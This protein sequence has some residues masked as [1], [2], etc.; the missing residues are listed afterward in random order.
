MLARTLSKVAARW[1]ASHDRMRVLFPELQEQCF[2]LL[3][4]SEKCKLSLVC[5]SWR[6]T[7]ACLGALWNT[8]DLTLRSPEFDFDGLLKRSGRLPLDLTLTVPAKQS[9]LRVD[10]C[11]KSQA[12]RLRS[13]T[14]TV[15]PEGKKSDPILRYPAPRLERLSLKYDGWNPAWELDNPTRLFD[16]CAP[17]LHSLY[18]EA[19]AFPVVCPA[20]AN[21]TSATVKC[22]PSG[23]TEIFTVMPALQHLVIDLPRRKAIL[24]RVPANARLRSIVVSFDSLVGANV[25]LDQVTALGYANVASCA[26]LS[27]SEMQPFVEFVT[28]FSEQKGTAGPPPTLVL[29][30]ADGLALRLKRTLTLGVPVPRI[31][32]LQRLF[33]GHPAVDVVARLELPRALDI[34]ARA[35][36]AFSGSRTEFRGVRTL[37]V[38][39]GARVPPS[40]AL[41]AIPFL[42]PPLGVPALARLELLPHADEP[43]APVDVAQLVSF[44]EEGLSLDARDKLELFVDT[45]GGIRLAGDVDQLRSR[46]RRLVT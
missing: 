4:V 45:A 29:S 3:P 30:Q 31:P 39:C 6:S 19:I 14:L 42:R 5:C 26:L 13:L 9:L 11:L 36:N 1:N 23:L 38:R 25:T 20:F 12:H 46:V 2:S 27:A 21:V 24:P 43:P 32:D 34:R 40:G 37:A 18:L 41:L 15:E 7:T 22:T 16:G 17:E 8:L 44:I 28:H 10:G 33:G 35:A